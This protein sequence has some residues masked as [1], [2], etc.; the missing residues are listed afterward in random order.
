[1]LLL[2]NLTVWTSVQSAYIPVPF[3]IIFFSRNYLD[4]PPGSPR[5]GIL[6]KWNGQTGQITTFYRDSEGKTVFPISWS[7][8]GQWFAVGVFGGTPPDRI[9]ILNRRG[10]L[11]RCFEQGI[12]R[13]AGTWFTRQ[14]FPFRWSQ[15]EKHVSF[16][17]DILN[18][19]ELIEVNIATGKTTRTW[20]KAYRSLGSVPFDWTSDF[21]YISDA[22]TYAVTHLH[23]GTATVIPL[24]RAEGRLRTPPTNPDDSTSGMLRICPF[25]PK[26]IYLPAYD[27]ADWFERAAL[28]F[29]LFNV[30][31]GEEAVLWTSTTHKFPLPASCPAWL[32]DESAFYALAVRHPEQRTQRTDLFR[33]DLKSSTG[34][35]YYDPSKNEPVDIIFAPRLSPD[36]Q[37]L[38][39]ET[40]HNPSYVWRDNWDM[41]AVNGR[42]GIIG[43]N[44]Q[45]VYI[46]S[47]AHNSTLPIWI[48]PLATVPVPPNIIVPPAQPTLVNPLPGGGGE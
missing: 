45:L 35:L 21:A 10:G 42:V 15:D 1:L 31:T 33:Y 38:A 18:S 32:A 5:Q 20:H 36:G 41:P 6:E 46:E 14:L 24:A 39:F 25:S 29:T 2:A 19:Y 23:S 4:S 28:E 34:T 27:N 30:K 8:S 9:C 48:P 26:G 43:P 3:D 17:Y 12:H 47:E 7:P 16:V 44:N 40:N 11:E 22:N 37:Y 13:F